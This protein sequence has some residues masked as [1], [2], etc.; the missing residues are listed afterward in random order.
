MKLTTRSRY[1]TRLI[2]DMALHGRDGPVRIKDV[3]A[4]QGISLKYLEKLVRELKAA[5]LVKSRRGPHGG[6]VLAR[7]LEEITIGAVVRALEGDLELVECGDGEVSCPRLYEC[8]TRDVWIEA[9]RAMHAKLD[10]FTLADLVRR[11]AA[12]AGSGPGATPGTS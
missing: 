3:A 2:L 7:P 5:G 1:G 6:H 11:G 4:R 10:S 12:R 8:L 9:A